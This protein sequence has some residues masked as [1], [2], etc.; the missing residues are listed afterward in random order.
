MR[1]R[2]TPIFTERQAKRQAATNTW[3]EA[4]LSANIKYVLIAAVVVIGQGVVWYSSQFWALFFLQAVQKLDVVTSSIIVGIALLLATPF[5]VIL[6]GRSARIA[7]KPI[8]LGGIALAA[9]P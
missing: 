3:R 4:F 2:E 9:I 5:F 7:R 6:G 8:I 1:L